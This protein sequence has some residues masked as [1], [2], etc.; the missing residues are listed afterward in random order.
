MSSSKTNALQRSGARL[1]STI[2]EYLPDPFT[3]GLILT[4]VAAAAALATG[5]GPQKIVNGWIDSFWNLLT[6]TLQMVLILVAGYAL[7]QHPRVK[8]FLLTLAHLPQSYRQAIVFTAIVA[9]IASWIN[10]GIGLIV[11]GILARNIGV[12]AVQED[13]FTVHYPLLCAAAFMGHGTMWH[14]GLSSSVGLFLSTPEHAFA[15]ITNGTI[16]TAATIFS[17]YALLFVALNF[18]VV[19][20]VLYLLA[21][22]EENVMDASEYLDEDEMVMADGSGNVNSG[23]DR[24]AG[25][26]L[27]DRDTNQVADKLNNSKLLGLAVGI[28]G[29]IWSIWTFSQQGVGALNFNTINFTLL[30]FGLVLYMSPEAYMREFYYAVESAAGIILQFHFYAGILGIL[31]ASGLLVAMTNAFTAVAPPGAYAS[32]MYLIA[33]FINL[34]VPSGG[35]QWIVMGQPVLQSAAQSGVPFGKA[36]V[37]FMVGDMHTDLLIP[38]WSLPLLG[39]A[40]MRARDVYGYCAAVFIVLVPIYFT[41]FWFLPYPLF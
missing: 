38:F 29:A 23:R 40:G 10:W 36:A 34:I 19:L 35:G 4:L 24:K 39:I 25:G 26:Y 2:E 16:S 17:P 13:D 21:P 9:M 18:V 6:F 15:E 33:G 5:T 14:L 8:G 3:I 37:S 27:D 41:V 7:A 22:N 20:P 1:A 32:A 30:A 28:P 31:T 12:R 11:G